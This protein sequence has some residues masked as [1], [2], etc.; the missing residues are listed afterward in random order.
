MNIPTAHSSESLERFL[1]HIQD[2]PIP[3]QVN[4]NYL[5]KSGFT[6]GNDPELRHI[7]RLLGFLNDEDM[8]TERWHQ[9]KTEGQKILKEAILDTYKPVFDI[10]QN[11]PERSEEELTTWFHPPLTGEARSAV[12]RAIR[13]FRKL[14][15]IAGI[16]TGEVVKKT[17]TASIKNVEEQSVSNASTGPG[18][19]VIQPPN[20][21]NEADYIRFFTALKKV[22]YE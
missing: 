4:R 7:G 9:Y 19:V 12:E 14:C 8:P 13:T 20:F 1:R 2:S 15:Q 11:A 3:K 16:T 18:P 6:S 21:K 5:K 22:F 17:S 10:F